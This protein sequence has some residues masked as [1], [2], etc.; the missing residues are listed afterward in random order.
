MVLREND[1][2]RLNM[3]MKHEPDLRSWMEAWSMGSIL[4]MYNAGEKF[5]RYFRKMKESVYKDKRE[6]TLVR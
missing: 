1:L 3:I 2:K 4:E 6:L 5:F